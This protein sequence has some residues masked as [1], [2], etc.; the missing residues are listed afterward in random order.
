MPPGKLLPNPKVKI[1]WYMV[2]QSAFDYNEAEWDHCLR[3]IGKEE[4]S[5][6]SCLTAHVRWLEMPGLPP[7]SRPSWTR[8]DSHPPR[9]SKK[10]VS[11]PFDLIKYV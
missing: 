3:E 4:P 10:H 6:F 5:T 2:T 8:V 11:S 1:G 7:L 9:S